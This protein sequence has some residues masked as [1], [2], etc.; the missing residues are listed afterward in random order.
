MCHVFE[1]SGIKGAIA[2]VTKLPDNAVSF[3][4]I[5]MWLYFV[6]IWLLM[7]AT[8]QVQADVA[9]ALRGKLDLF[10]LEVFS[11]F[12]PVLAVLLSSKTER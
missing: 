2:A 4:E 6:L 8:I 3:S 12:L 7:V 1:K 9:S 11:S 10:N 5:Y